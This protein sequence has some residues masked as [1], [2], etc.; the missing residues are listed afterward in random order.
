MSIKQ[1]FSQPIHKSELIEVIKQGLFMALIGGLLI[2]SLQLLLRFQ[3]NISLTWLMLIILASLIAKRIKNA[4]YEPH[5]IY[6]LISV[7]AFLIG[8]YLM[9]AVL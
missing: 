3:F 1:Q 7:T 8:Y 9:T 4:V 6:S 2:G 5:I